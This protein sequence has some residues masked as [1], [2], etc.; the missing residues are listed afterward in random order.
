MRRLH[1][2]Q[3]GQNIELYFK[4]VQAGS[5]AASLSPTVDTR[6]IAA[7]DSSQ[8]TFNGSKVTINPILD[9]VPNTGYSVLIDSGAIMDVDGNA[10]AG[11]SD[12]TA[13][14]FTTAADDG[15]LIVSPVII[16]SP[17]LADSDIAGSNFPII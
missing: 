5:A 11:I 13:L 4:W 3:V 2:L 9:L 10:Y 17:G 7:N 16:G 15:T 8:I 1:R 14:N 6:T 12:D